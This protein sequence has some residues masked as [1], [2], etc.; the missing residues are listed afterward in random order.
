MPAEWAA[1]KNLRR[2][3]VGKKWIRLRTLCLLS[4]LFTRRGDICLRLRPS[5]GRIQRDYLYLPILYEEMHTG[6]C[7]DRSEVTLFNRAI[8]PLWHRP[9]AVVLLSTVRQKLSAEVILTLPGTAKWGVY[10]QRRRALCNPGLVCPPVA[11]H[12]PAE[13]C[14][15][16]AR[17]RRDLPP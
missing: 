13:C 12:P 10:M 7:A 5:E 15:K 4:P 9:V 3:R 16:A 6:T 11:P 8:P 17:S 2:S 14:R 1:S